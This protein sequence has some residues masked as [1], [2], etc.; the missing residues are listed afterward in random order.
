MADDFKPE[1]VIRLDHKGAL[2]WALAFS[3]DGKRALSG[4]EDGRVRL[5]EVETGRCLRVLEGHTAT[6]WNVAWSGDQRRA[7][8]GDTVG[9]IRVWDLSEFLTNA[10]APEATAA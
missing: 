2:L 4:A 8:S 5:W 10:Q 3:P 1:Q 6:I 7:L 9:G